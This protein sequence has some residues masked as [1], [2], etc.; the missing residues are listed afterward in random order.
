MWLTQVPNA[1]NNSCCTLF[2][3]SNASNVNEFAPSR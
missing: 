2:K 3:I 1:L